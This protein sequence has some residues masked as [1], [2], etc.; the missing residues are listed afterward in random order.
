MFVEDFNVLW[1]LTFDLWDLLSEPL[2]LLFSFVLSK[3]YLH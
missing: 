3:G 1:L 2:F